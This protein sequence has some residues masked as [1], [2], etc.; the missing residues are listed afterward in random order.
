MESLDQPVR[1][2]IPETLDAA[3]RRRLARRRYVFHADSGHGWLAVKR[4]DVDALGIGAD[5]SP[6]SYQRGETVYLEEDRD[7]QLFARAYETAVGRHPTIKRGASP[8]R[9]PIRSYASYVPSPAAGSSSV[10][11][12]L[13]DVPGGRD[14]GRSRGAGRSRVRNAFGQDCRRG[15]GVRGNHYGDVRSVSDSLALLR[16]A[17][18]LR[19]IRHCDAGHETQS[20]RHR[21]LQG[22]YDTAA[23]RMTGRVCYVN[24]GQA[25]AG[26]WRAF[27]AGRYPRY[28]RRVDAEL[29]ADRSIRL[30]AY[31][32]PAALPDSV[33]EHFAN[34]G[35]GWTGA[36]NLLPHQPKRL[37]ECRTHYG[38][39]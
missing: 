17:V 37:R 13:A 29:L 8:D 31:G 32:D 21:P 18:G 30:G 33:V 4:A 12:A 20:D 22:V 27:R 39:R 9:S 36:A 28:R 16:R 6:Y 24:V 11:E 25:P 19:R 5:V 1:A 3:T 35:R 10:G 23:G 34:V 38:T 15:A 7:A 2:S 14:R 26:V